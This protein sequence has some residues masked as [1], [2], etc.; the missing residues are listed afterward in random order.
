MAASASMITA[1]TAT[2]ANHLWSAGTTFHGA[3][4]VLV[5]ESA[6]E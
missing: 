1:A 5:W 4:S 6:S 2:R 3:A